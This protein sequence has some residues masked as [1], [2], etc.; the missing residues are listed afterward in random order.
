MSNIKVKTI[1]AALGK[2]GFQMERQK[3]HRLWVFYLNGKKTSIRTFF[4]HGITDYSDSLLGSMAKQVRLSRENLNSLI[5]CP[6]SHEEYLSLM[7]QEGYI[8]E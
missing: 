2:K 6:L 5:E 4:S 8:R 1:E 3:K 7:I